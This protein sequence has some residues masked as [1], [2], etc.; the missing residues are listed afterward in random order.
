MNN[1]AKIVG[2]LMLTYVTHWGATNVYSYVCLP[3]GFF[4]FFQGMINTGSPMCTTTLNFVTA[5]QA[6][7][8]TILTVTLSRIVMDFILPTG[9][10]EKKTVA[11]PPAV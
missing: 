10:Y 8:A 9:G 2:S 7:Y 4:G 1:V 11:E 6:S 3:G 5:T